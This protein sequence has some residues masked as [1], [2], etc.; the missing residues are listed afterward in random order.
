[1][2]AQSRFST[3]R[4]PC[5]AALP[6]SCG[7]EQISGK[8]EIKRLSPNF[9]GPGAEN[10]EQLKFITFILPD[11]GFNTQNDKGIMLTNLFQISLINDIDIRPP[12]RYKPV[13]IQAIDFT[14]TN[15]ID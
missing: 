3:K 5:K 11:T 13:A 6:L 9:C 15:N 7:F 2:I 12:Y 1:M 10:S 8:Q 4:R 14:K